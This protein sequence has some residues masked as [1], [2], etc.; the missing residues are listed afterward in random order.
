[1]NIKKNINS[2]E[3]A[4]VGLS[5]LGTVAA[6]VTQQIAYIA[7]PLTLSLSLSLIRVADMGC[8]AEMDA[9]NRRC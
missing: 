7:T 1:M 9:A 2:T 8:S 5:V 6:I 4:S 3:Y